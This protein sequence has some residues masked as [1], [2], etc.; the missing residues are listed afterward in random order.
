MS[1]NAATTYA[2]NINECADSIQYLGP[3]RTIIVRGPMGWGKSSLLK[4]MRKRLGDGFTYVYFDC[5]TKLDTSDLHLPQFM[6]T[7]DGEQFVRY[8]PVEEFGLHYRKPIV[9]NID[10][11]GKAEKSVKAALMRDLLERHRFPAGSIVFG[12][13]N[14]SNERLGDLLMPHHRN[15]LD[16]INMRNSTQEEWIEDFAY[17]ANI[18][19][20]VIGWVSEHP[21]LFITFTDLMDNAGEIS[22]PTKDAHPMIYI[23]GDVGREAFVTGRSLEAASDVLHSLD[24]RVTERVVTAHLIGTIGPAAALSLAAYHNVA[25]ELPR[26][27]D[28]KAS[29]LA[30][31]V[32]THP[33]AACMTVHRT[34]A[35]IERNWMDSWMDYLARLPRTVQ[36]MFAMVATKKNYHK[37]DIVMSNSKFQRWA[38]TN[39]YISAQ[40]KV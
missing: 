38:L 9:L 5:T 29:P 22:K 24:G 13:T 37:R 12:T 30:A 7:D 31:L 10:E 33:A 6:Q 40:D 27:A 14:L 32:P 19:P 15:R 36:G 25:N 21:E 16:V 8:V 1:I 3:K 34:L 4:L 35:L 20:S 18:H 17:E 2:L 23:P 11:I 28:I 26:L 39:N